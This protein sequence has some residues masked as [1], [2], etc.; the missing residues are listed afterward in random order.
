MQRQRLIKE[1]LFAALW[2]YRHRSATPNPKAPHPKLKATVAAGAD[3]FR[4]HLLA[5]QRE[6]G[7]P[8]D[9]AAAKALAATASTKL[10]ELLT[11]YQNIFSRSSTRL[12]QATHVRCL[13]SLSPPVRSSHGFV[14]ARDLLVMRVFHAVELIRLPTI[15]AVRTCLHVASSTYINRP[16]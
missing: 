14:R 9:A 11:T 1:D 15:P 5:H 3:V 6:A 16:D 10:Q 12:D 13:P 7:M 8:P 4:R 2:N